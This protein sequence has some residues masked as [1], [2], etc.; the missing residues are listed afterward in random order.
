M[1]CVKCFSEAKGEDQ[2]MEEIQVNSSLQ[3]KEIKVLQK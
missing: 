2:I 3:T 1:K